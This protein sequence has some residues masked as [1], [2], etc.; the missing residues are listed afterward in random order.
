MLLEGHRHAGAVP[1]TVQA[2]VAARLDALPTPARDVAR[3]SSV[4]LS[5]FDRDEAA[6]LA[7]AEGAIDTRL[8]ELEDAELL[9]RVDDGAPRW[10]FRHQTLRDVAYASLP[11]RQRRELHL[12]VADRLVADG[13][14]SWAA[15]HLEQA[16]LAALDLEPA[17]RELPDRAAD[18]LAEAGDRARRRMENRSALGRY[19]RALALAGDGDG[20]GVREARVLAGMGEAFYWLGEYPGADR[21]PRAGRRARHA[22]R[23]RLDARARAPV[24]RRHL[25][26][27]APPTSTGRRSCS[28][29]PSRRPSG[30]ASRPRSPARCCSPAGCRGPASASRMPRRS[31]GGR[32]RS[33][34]RT[35]IGGPASAPSARSRS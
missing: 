22:P 15:D 29:V 16:A 2:V 32:S 1:P 10:R 3:R 35:T 27:R 9:V 18:A 34:R 17:S 7:P 8:Q 19:R 5:S 28:I 30:S 26:Q 25:D 14:R 23:R 20:W 12:V 21:G 11:K 13:H 24:P 31:G 33:P 6:A 4:F